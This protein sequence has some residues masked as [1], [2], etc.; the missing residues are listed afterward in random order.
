MIA[1]QRADIPAPDP[2]AE[3]ARHRARLSAPAHRLH[4]H[5]SGRRHRHAART[6]PAKSSSSISS[7]RPAPPPAPTSTRRWKKSSRPRRASPC[8]SSPS[9]WTPADDNAT[10]LARYAPQYSADPARWSFLT[11]DKGVIHNLVGVSFL[12]PDTTGEFSYMPGNFAHV[13]RIVLV[14][15]SGK[16]V[17][18]STGSI[19]TRPNPYS[20]RSSNWK[21]SREASPHPRRAAGDSHAHRL[22]RTQVR[23]QRPLLRGARRHPAHLRRPA[24]R[25]HPA[26]RHSRLHGRDDHGLSRAR[27]ASARRPRPRRPNRFHA[28]GGGRRRVRQPGQTHRPH[29]P[30]RRSRRDRR[31]AHARSRRLATPMPSSSRKMAATFTS[32]IFAARPSRSLSSSR[33][34]RCRIIAR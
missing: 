10:V 14:D 18:Y 34:A 7:T 11:G 20:R 12:P 21:R 30:A 22:P 23:H 27:S 32:P 25:H 8:G 33:A 29:R 13:Q 4:A 1:L 26:R 5:R 3:N 9:R 31:H 28:L 2:D 17:S 15:Q 6:S 24:H 16:I 19:P